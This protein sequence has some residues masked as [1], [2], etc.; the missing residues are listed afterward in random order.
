MEQYE[1]V[2][3]IADD[4]LLEIARMAESRIEAVI[5]IK[6][7]A[8]KVT[9]ASD[10]TDQQGKPYI[11]AS[12][13]EK[14]ANLFNISVRFLTPEPTYQ[15]D[16]DG[17]Y[18]YIFSGSFSMGNRSIEVEGSRSSRDPFFKQNLYEK[19]A[20]GKNKLARE[21][22]IEE[23]DNKRDVRMAAYTNLLG[24]GITRLLGIRNLTWEDLEVFAGIKK[25]Q[26]GKVEYKNKGEKPPLT[27]PGKKSDKEAP[28]TEGEQTV[29]VKIGEIASKDGKKKDGSPY[30]IFTIFDD[31][32]TRYGTFD[33][34]FADLSELSK[35]EG[36]PVNITFTEGQFGRKIT[37]LVAVERQPG[38]DPE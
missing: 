9:N 22:K 16:P 14:I 17:H 3:A 6:Q 2:P 30:T 28:K 23:R 15:E 31:T 4:T 32:G 35:Q 37:N 26:V 13:S 11:Q 29:T 21:K 27:Q 38:D 24:N 12:G 34:K 25:E 19:D 36:F 7:L 5:K 18:T 10:W 33:T 1:G 8:L 20:E